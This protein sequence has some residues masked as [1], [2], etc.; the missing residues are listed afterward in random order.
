MRRRVALG[1]EVA[2]NYR[3]VDWA[4]AVREATAGRGV[5]V[6][7]DIVGGDYIPATSSCWRS[8][9]GCCRSRF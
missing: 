5:D 6:I 3:D 1:A 4:A 8:K 7:L 2:F 9:A